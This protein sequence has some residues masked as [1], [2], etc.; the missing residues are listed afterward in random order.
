MNISARKLRLP[1]L[2]EDHSGTCY[3]VGVTLIFKYVDIVLYV[4]ISKQATIVHVELI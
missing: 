4:D 1:V 3:S 2:S